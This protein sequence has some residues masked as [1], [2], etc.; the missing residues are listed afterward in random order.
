LAKKKYLSRREDS[1]IST[2]SLYPTLTSGKR[3]HQIPSERKKKRGQMKKRDS[4]PLVSFLDPAGRGKGALEENRNQRQ[5]KKCLSHLS[6]EDR[7]E[8]RQRNC[9]T[10]RKPHKRSQLCNHEKGSYRDGKKK[11]KKKCLKEVGV[12][13]MPLATA[14][15]MPDL[16]PGEKKNRTASARK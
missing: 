8:S 2:T 7:A 1:E 6:E 5:S 14:R 15:K 11:E 13:K 12:E 4:F 16:S 3:R 10:R 9:S